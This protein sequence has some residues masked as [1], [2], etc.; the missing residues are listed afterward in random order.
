MAE[1]SKV[2]IECGIACNKP[3]SDCNALYAEGRECHLLKVYY[4]FS[5]TLYLLITVTKYQVDCKLID[6]QEDDAIALYMK[7][8]IVTTHLLTYDKGKLIFFSSL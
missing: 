7:H 6:Y 1:A 4:I 3:G 2:L 8:S 5:S